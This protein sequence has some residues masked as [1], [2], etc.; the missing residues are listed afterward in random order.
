MV[1]LAPVLAE[2]AVR[3]VSLPVIGDVPA[4][5]VLEGRRELQSRRA[6]PRQGRS[7]RRLDPG[8]D[9]VQGPPERGRASPGS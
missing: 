5:R 8:C 3:L 4:D 6:S 9:L 1:Q 7:H 2:H